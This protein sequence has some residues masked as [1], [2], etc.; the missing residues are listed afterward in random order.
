MPCEPLAVM[1]QKRALRAARPSLTLF[2]G[3]STRGSKAHKGTI[4]QTESMSTRST[5]MV[6]SAF[7]MKATLYY[8]LF[9]LIKGGKNMKKC[10]KTEAAILQLLEKI[11]VEPL[12]PLPLQDEA[13]IQDALKKV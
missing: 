6:A 9:T 12:Q 8:S 1:P 3:M 10:D 2:W 7:D 4:E 11:G 13:E 5:Y